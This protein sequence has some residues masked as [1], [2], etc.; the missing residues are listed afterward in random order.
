[1]ICL[2]LSGLHMLC[3]SLLLYS[4]SVNNLQAK[5]DALEKSNTKLTEEVCINILN[6]TVYHYMVKI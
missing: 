2:A 3:I 5:V 6:P 4:A 1:M